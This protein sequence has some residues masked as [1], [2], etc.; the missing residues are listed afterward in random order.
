MDGPILDQTALR[1]LLAKAA[2]SNRYMLSNVRITGAVTKL[3]ASSPEEAGLLLMDVI[4]EDGR[5]LAITPAGHHDA[6]PHGASM[7]RIDAGGRLIVPTFIDC[8]TH[9]DK[10]HILPRTPAA[11]GTFD[12]AIAATR[13]DRTTNWSAADVGKRMDFAL[14]SAF[15]HGTSAIRTH[16]DSQ[17]PQADISWPVF[18]EFR[19]HWHGRI[20]LQASCL[21]PIDMARDDDF[22]AHTARRVADTG[23]ILGA[24]V[25][26]APD[27]DHLLDKMFKT[28]MD[29]G[30]DLDFHADETADPAANALRHIAATSLRRL[31]S[32]KILV[33]HCCSLATQDVSTVEATLDVVQ[34]AGIA[35][36][37]LPTCNLYL[38]DRR[39][40][41]TTP[42]WRGVTLLHEMKQRGIPVAL[43]SDNTRDPFNP[44]GDLDMLETFRLGTRAL[45]LD[46]PHGDWV[47]AVSTTPAGIM[48]L[49]GRGVIAAGYPADFILFEGRSWSEV[50]SRSE[51]N[52]LVVRNG[53]P[54]SA[55]LPAYHELD[56]LGG[57][58][59][60]CSGS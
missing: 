42:R 18:A 34:R 54:V 17:M 22:L 24:V 36:V 7:G 11:D 53:I 45:H 33:G 26:P 29:H 51:S 14:R 40:N 16:L 44:Y 21:F 55:P 19:Q 10:S 32:G 9:L 8:H 48:G 41:H 52:R 5:I 39:D 25:Y 23:G 6:G 47:R 56:E 37:S 30:L 58:G 31:F 13:L 2:D 27:I 46:H 43:A 38:Q 60:R 4:V 59:D 50:M 20:D 28:A 1:A 35:I 12:G 3:G 57:I 49:E 15:H